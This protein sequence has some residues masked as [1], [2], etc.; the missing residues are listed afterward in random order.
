M[1]AG[2]LEQV[3]RASPRTETL[4]MLP[5]VDTTGVVLGVVSLRRLLVSDP[6][7]PVHELMSTAVVVRVD[8]DQ[9]DAARPGLVIEEAH[10]A[11][12]AAEGAQG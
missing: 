5:V 10:P 1:G 7:V 11:G 12:A 3:R 8:Q 4:Y 6:E 2:H 9:E